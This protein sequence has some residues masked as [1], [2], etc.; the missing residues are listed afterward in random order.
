M[1]GNGQSRAFPEGFTWGTATAAHQIEGG[2]FNNDW[3]EFDMHRARCAPNPP[4]T[5]VT[6]GNAGKRT[7]I[8]SRVWGWT[9]PGSLSSGAGSSQP[10]AR[11][12]TPRSPT[13]TG[14]VTGFVHA[15]STPS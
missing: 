9:I 3:W 1:T 12:P 4:V 6:H 5:P 11:S 15:G 8:S 2:N 10:R 14:S 7:P 13:T